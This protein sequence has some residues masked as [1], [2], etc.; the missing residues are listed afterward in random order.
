MCVLADGRLL[1]RVLDN[2]ITNIIKYAQPGKRAYF[3]LTET[4]GATSIAVKNT[5]KALLDIPA[6]ELMERLSGATVPGAPREAAWGCP[7]PGASPSSWAAKCASPWT[8]TFSRQ[9]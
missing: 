5:S 8:G 1:G 6:D 4:D 2:L 7:P 9:R 3:D